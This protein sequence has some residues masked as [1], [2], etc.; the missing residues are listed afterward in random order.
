MRLL[1]V[2]LRGEGT[3]RNEQQ[4]VRM[5]VSKATKLVGP[6]MPGLFGDVRDH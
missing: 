4:S 1:H 3:A 5:R 6:R 2:T